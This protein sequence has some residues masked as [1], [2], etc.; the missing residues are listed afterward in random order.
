MLLAC[1]IGALT[2]TSCSALQVDTVYSPAGT[3][4][5]IVIVRHGER[6]EGLDP[7][8]NEEGLARAQALADELAEAGVTVVMYPDLMRNRQ[9]ADPLVERTGAARREFSAVEAADTK[10]LANNFVDEV[11]ADYAGGVVVMKTGTATLSPA[12]LEDAVRSDPI[13]LEELR[14]VAS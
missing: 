14:W 8:L 9:T 3:E 5:T 11:L 6:D 10:A 13:P 1:G 7:P 4:T 2:L 12:E